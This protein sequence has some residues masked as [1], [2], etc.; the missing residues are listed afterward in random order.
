MPQVKEKRERSLG[1]RLHL[2]GDRCNSPK[3]AA[4]RKPYRP[5]VHGPKKPTR[6]ISEFGRQV[7]EKQ[8]F[9]L[10]YGINENNLAQIFQNAKKKKGSTS[11]EILSLLERR[12]SNIVFRLSLAPSRYSAHQL[13]LHGHILVNKKRVKSPGFL[14]KAGDTVSFRV[15]S[16]KMKNVTPLHEN[17]K[18][19][20]PPSWL[21]INPET[22]EG[23]VLN[24]PEEFESPFEINLL[25]ESFS[26]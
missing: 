17:L 25:V 8:K 7:T 19:Y 14:V 26:K 1:E 18:K 5:G 24:I 9:K 3:C 12:L 10:T 11:N 6:S 21:H 4:V 2:K 16:Q 13:V 23:K 20:E 15:E 22:L